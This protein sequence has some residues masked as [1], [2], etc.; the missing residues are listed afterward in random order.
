MKHSS[1]TKKY[2]NDIFIYLEDPFFERENHF[3]KA[4]FLPVENLEVVII[5]GWISFHSGGDNP[6]TNGN[7]KVRFLQRSYSEREMVIQQYS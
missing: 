5:P 2:L 7:S 4:K 6:F 1:Q 3:P